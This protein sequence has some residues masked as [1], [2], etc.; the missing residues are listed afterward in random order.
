[1]KT[2]L[3]LLLLCVGFPIA[4]VAQFSGDELKDIAWT[5]S[6]NRHTDSFFVGLWSKRALE[7]SQLRPIRRRTATGGVEE[8]RDSVQMKAS[9]RRQRSFSY[10]MQ[11][12]Y[13]QAVA[14]L[15]ESAALDPK[16]HFAA[17]RTYLRNLRDYPRALRHLDAYD[18]LT[19]D[20][21][22]ND[23]IFPI[24]YLKGLCYRNMG[25]HAEAVRQFSK[26]IDSLAAK[27]GAEWVNYKQYVSR[28]ISYLSVNQPDKALGDLVI[29]Q[30]N[31]SP[32]SPLVY[33]YKGKTLRQMG[34][35]AEGKQAF[36]EAQF[37]WQ[38]NRVKGIGQPEDYNNP[39]IEE[40]IDEALKQ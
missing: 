31:A 38:A 9:N 13:E 39:V 3:L 10:L 20:F 27:H 7:S 1:M 18:A 36:Q 21:D 5:L 23:G 15:E 33:F 28:A 17:G 30:K 29:A 6:M 4:S 16:E 24:S 12:N 25:N 34:R 22:D 35:M 32:A 19:P 14:L 8:I 11:Q 2:S 37:F 26:G 40:D